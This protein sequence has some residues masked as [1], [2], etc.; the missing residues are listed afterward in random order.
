VDLSGA[1]SVDVW[2]EERLEAAPLE[3]FLSVANAAERAR[4]ARFV[5][6]APR[7]NYI[8][9][10]VFLR[11]VLARYLDCEPAGVQIV[12]GDT[13]K[14]LLKDGGLW[15][16]LSHSHGMAAVAVT[17]CGSVGIDV[18]QVRDLPEQDSIAARYFPPGEPGSFFERWTRL[19]ALVKASG[20]GLGAPPEKWWVANVA[21]PP[22]Y[23]AAVSV[24]RGPVPIRYQKL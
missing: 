16:N 17:R 13:G 23:V 19:E 9:A 24:E 21:A 8:S 4:A 6:A 3:A 7:E 22:G 5:V 10:H 14:P 2:F 15:F 18:E 11:R 20:R 1:E 12:A